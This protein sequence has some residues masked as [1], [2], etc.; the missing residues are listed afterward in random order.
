MMKGKIVTSF[1]EDMSAIWGRNWSVC[2]EIG[3]LKSVLLRRPGDEVDNI[4]SADEAHMRAIPDP[5]KLRYA[6][7]LVANTYREHGIEVNYIEDMDSSCPNAMYVRDLVLGTPEGVII[8]RPGIKIRSKEVKYAAQKVMQL[9]IPIVGTIHG[10][11]IFD[12]ACLTWIDRETVIIGT[13]TRCNVEGLTQI[14]SLLKP[15]GVKNF[16]ELS[17]A[18]NQNHL[19]GFLAIVDYNIAVAFPYITPQIIYDELE[20][21]GFKIIEIPSMEE[22]LNF[23]A[24]SVALAPGKI[25]MAN[26]CPET[27]KLLRLNGI[28]VIEIDVDE[29]KKG[30]GSIHCLTAFLERDSI[31]L[32]SIDE[33]YE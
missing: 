24:N 21:R 9:G 22:K 11:A 33:N 8:S 20:K 12:G 14:K 18:R 3:K 25:L 2:S 5:I 30:G 28:E 31:P 27:T 23:A 29:I 15:M 4:I 17:I 26:G 32:Y 6:H 19:D 16:I 1:K 10:K 7:D 13:G